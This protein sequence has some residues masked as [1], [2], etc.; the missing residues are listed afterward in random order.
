M[1]EVSKDWTLPRAIFLGHEA[2][3]DKDRKVR[4][5]GYTERRPCGYGASWNGL[6]I[7]PGEVLPNYFPIKGLSITRGQEVIDVP[8]RIGSTVQPIEVARVLLEFAGCN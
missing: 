8:S 6:T 1:C 3:N 4:F 2:T 5:T 7:M